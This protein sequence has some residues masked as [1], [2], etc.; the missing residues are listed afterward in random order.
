ME[1]FFSKHEHREIKRETVYSVRKEDIDNTGN[2]YYRH[3]TKRNRLVN[4][5]GKR[6]MRKEINKYASNTL[7]RMIKIIFQWVCFKH[8]NLF[9]NSSDIKVSF[10][11]LLLQTKD[12]TL[13]KTVS[14]NKEDYIRLKSLIQLT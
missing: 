2:E 11:H 10:L 4:N 6:E 1:I 9:K 5:T 8:N 14:I 7:S 3:T 12:F 13:Y